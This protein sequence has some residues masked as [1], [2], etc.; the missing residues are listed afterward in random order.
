MADLILDPSSLGARVKNNDDWLLRSQNLHRDVEKKNGA[1]AKRIRIA[2]GY[3]LKYL[4]YLM[5]IS[6]SHLGDLERG[7][8]HW[9]SD[10]LD[11]WEKSMNSR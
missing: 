5:G 11:S 8:R 10:T 6:V 1:D 2:A 3:S 7:H 9:T 4:A